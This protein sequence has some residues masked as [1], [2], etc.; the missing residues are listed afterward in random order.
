MANTNNDD[1]TYTDMGTQCELLKIIKTFNENDV[2]PI[3]NI[4]DWN[5]QPPLPQR[6]ARV[7]SADRA[8]ERTP[9]RNGSAQASADECTPGGSSVGAIAECTAQGRSPEP[10]CSDSVDSRVPISADTAGERS[11]ANKPGPASSSNAGAAASVREGAE[12]T[13]DSVGPGPSHS[14]SRQPI[15]DACHRYACVAII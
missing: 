8:G 10:R 11:A 6:R 5:M 7:R 3:M 15:I 12:C 2:W 1:K 4:T 14:E 9:G 13:A